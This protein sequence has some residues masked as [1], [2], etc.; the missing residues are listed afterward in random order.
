V[1]TTITG[2]PSRQPKTRQT[3]VPPML[4]LPWRRM[5]VRFAAPTSQ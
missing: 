4:L 3:F 1:S 2:S 5:S